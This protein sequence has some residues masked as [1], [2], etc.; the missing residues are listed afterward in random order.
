MLCSGMMAW[1]IIGALP[2][3]FGFIISLAIANGLSQATWLETD[4]AKEGKIFHSGRS[5]KALKQYRQRHPGGRKH[6]HALNA[7]LVAAGFA[8][9]LLVYIFIMSR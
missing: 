1:K 9:G 8:G 6:I 3:F 5:W 4:E 7:A 2:F